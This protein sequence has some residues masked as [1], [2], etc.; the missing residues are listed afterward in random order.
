MD[1][2]PELKEKLRSDPEFKREVRDRIKAA[3]LDKVKETKKAEYQFDSY[4]LSGK[5][6]AA[7]SALVL[8]YTLDRQSGVPCNLDLLINVPSSIILSCTFCQC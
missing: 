7:V 8:F 3:L 1:L 2:R 4:M 6:K 5:S